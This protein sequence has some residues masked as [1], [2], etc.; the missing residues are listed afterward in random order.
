MQAYV[1]EKINAYSPVVRSHEANRLF[2]RY[3]HRSED[4][5]KMGLKDVAY[6]AVD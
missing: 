1:A 5:I 2:E 3:R 4:N 6:G